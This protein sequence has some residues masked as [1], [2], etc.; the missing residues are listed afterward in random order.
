M[1]ETLAAILDELA[2][3]AVLG[4]GLY[5]LDLLLAAW[6]QPAHRGSQRKR[7]GHRLVPDPDLIIA[8][9]HGLG[10]AEILHSDVILEPLRCRV[11]VTH[12][13]GDLREQGR[14]R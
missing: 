8:S 4:S 12:R 14:V 7:A 6:S 3:D 2:I 13:V 11:E 9:G 5:D 1:I 10:H